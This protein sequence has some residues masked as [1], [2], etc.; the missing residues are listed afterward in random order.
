MNIRIG[1]PRALLYYNYVTLWKTFFTLL[2][3]EVLISGHTT[4][5]TLDLGRDMVVD[6]ACLPVKIFFGHTAQLLEQKPDFLFVPRMV[7]VEKSAYICPKIIGLPDI[8]EAGNKEMPALIKPTLNMVSTG[9]I[10]SFLREAGS[11]LTTDRRKISRAWKIARHEQNAEDRKVLDK[12]RSMENEIARTGS[13]LPMLLLGHRYNLYDDFL[14]LNIRKRLWQMGCDLWTPEQFSEESKEDTI[15]T[16]PKAIFWT[17]GKNILG[18]V[19]CFSRLP[20]P[21]G[22]VI[23]SSFGCGIDSFIGN[24]AMRYLQ[25]A[26]IPYLN[27]TLDEHSGEAGLET[28]L[29]AFLDMIHWRRTFNED[30]ISSYGIPVGD[31]EGYAGIHGVYGYSATSYQ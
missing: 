16:L 9:N 26:G 31:P 12:S 15:K 10:D 24:M 18:T 17:F 7:S 14:N 3:A 28:R 8:L 23:I 21:K 20:G 29:E 1:I 4:K 25:K 13:K 2:G 11:C 22:V 30:H 19:R 6:E 27:I 5:L